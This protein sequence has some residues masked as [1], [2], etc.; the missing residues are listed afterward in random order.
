M[1]GRTRSAKMP[2][3]KHA[4]TQKLSDFRAAQMKK[5]IA[6]KESKKDKKRNKAR[7]SSKRTAAAGTLEWVSCAVMTFCWLTP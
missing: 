5:D 1:D 3:N 7:V 6:K 2:S 4:K